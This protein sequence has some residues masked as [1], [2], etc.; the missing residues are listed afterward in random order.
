MTLCVPELQ[1]EVRFEKTKVSNS[2][3]KPPS[4]M[5]YIHFVY[6][7]WLSTRVRKR[8]VSILF[9]TIENAAEVTSTLTLHR[10]F[11]SFSRTTSGQMLLLVKT[12]NIIYFSYERLLQVTKNRMSL[13]CLHMMIIGVIWPYRYLTLFRNT[14]ASAMLRDHFR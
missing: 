3:H 7:Y 14:W 6:L 12:R 1:P 9:N 13:S 4:K 5:H 11:G 10:Y 8:N 2:S